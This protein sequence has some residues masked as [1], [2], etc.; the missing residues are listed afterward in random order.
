MKRVI[1]YI[2][3]CLFIAGLMTVLSP[4][5][6]VFAQE[7]E[8]E[9]TAVTKKTKNPAFLNAWKQISATV[10]KKR[11]SKTAQGVET[12]GVRGKEAEDV[13]IEQMYFRGG[14]AYPARTKI[15]NAILVLTQ[16]IEEADASDPASTAEARFYIA[17]CYIELGHN[18]KAIAS[19][20]NVIKV[21]KKSQWAIQARAEIKRLSGK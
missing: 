8:T 11:T 16:T 1:V 21:A 6:G 12:A 9:K 13:I 2:I 14:T 20:E 4:D 17:Q 10:N 5:H 15:E 7:K 3:T 18:D 19:F